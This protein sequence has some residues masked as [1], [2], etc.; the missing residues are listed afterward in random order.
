MDTVKLFALFDQEVAQVLA[1]AKANTATYEEALNWLTVH[2]RAEKK[3]FLGIT[4]IPREMLVKEYARDVYFAAEDQ[5]KK[6][7]RK[8]PL[9]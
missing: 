5:L 9:R 2:A 3:R 7:A 8:L 1:D 4:T 6:E